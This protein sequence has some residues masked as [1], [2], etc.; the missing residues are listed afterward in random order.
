LAVACSA[1]TA[2]AG[3]DAANLFDPRIEPVNPT[4]SSTIEYI[5]GWDGSGNDELPS[6]VRSGASIDVTWQFHR[7]CGIPQPLSASFDIGALPPGSYVVHV[8]LCDL[9]FG[10]PENACTPLAQPAD[11]RFTVEA[12]PELPSLGSVACVILC[13]SLCGVA[14]ARR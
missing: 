6:I 11:T 2:W 14:I 3:G 9:G 10:T 1:T 5:V 12:A 4:S 7:V 13:L 8:D